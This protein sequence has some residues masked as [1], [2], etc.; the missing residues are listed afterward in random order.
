MRLRMLIAV[1]T[2]FLWSSGL[3]WADKYDVRSFSMK[4]DGTSTLHDW[5]TPVTKVRAKGDLTVVGTEIKSV[6]GIWV[7][8]E[9]KSIMS[10]KGESMDEKIYETLDADKNPMI[11]FNMTSMKS[12]RKEGNDYIIEAT[13]D[14]TIAGTTKKVDL[15]VRGVTQANGDVQLSGSTNISLANFGMERPS[16]MLGMVK[17][18]DMVTVS[19]TVTMK[20]S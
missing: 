5:T 1:A 15:K 3:A 2:A 11:T 14:L 10:D 6:N 19:F 12:I 20:K 18:G 17:A 16:A 9:A 7:Q 13:G 8:A 4:V